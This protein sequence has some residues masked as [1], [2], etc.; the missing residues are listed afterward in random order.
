MRC[1]PHGAVEIAAQF[2]QFSQGLDLQLDE[3]D[4]LSVF[5]ADQLN[6]DHLEA[7]ALAELGADVLLDPVDVGLLEMG[8]CGP[9]DPPRN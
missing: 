9:D 8:L 5:L 3:A 2:L 6:V 1:I 7:V 4:E